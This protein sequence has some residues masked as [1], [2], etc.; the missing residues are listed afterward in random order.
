MS[1]MEQRMLALEQRVAR[2]EA[3][4]AA[5][6]ALQDE[7]VAAVASSGAQ[8]STGETFLQKR[9]RGLLRD[10]PAQLQRVLKSVIEE[11]VE[12]VG[13][14]EVMATRFIPEIVELCENSSRTSDTGELFFQTLDERLQELLDAYSLEVVKP[15]HGEPFQTALHNAV[16]VVRG[17]EPQRRDQ[18]EL[19]LSPGFR[20]KGRLLKKAE[21]TVFL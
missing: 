15:S 13:D 3:A 21:V 16:R 14:E 8:E 1:E 12:R 17:A 5:S 10:A 11:A 18:V 9:L 19:C 7:P 20:W 6:G 2:L 4:L